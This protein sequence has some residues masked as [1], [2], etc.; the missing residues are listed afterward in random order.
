MLDSLLEIAPYLV[1]V[2]ASSIIAYCWIVKGLTPKDIW[3]ETTKAIRTA[4]A[5]I[6]GRE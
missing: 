6:L 1:I 5:V 2:E 4:L 3:K